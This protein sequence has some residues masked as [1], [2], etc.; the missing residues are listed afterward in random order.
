[1]YQFI[2]NGRVL[3]KHVAFFQHA[4]DA[5][6]G[7]NGLRKFF[8]GGGIRGGK[9][10][11]CLY[12]IIVACRSYQ[13]LRAH[14]IRDSLPSL[15]RTI[16]PSIKKLLIGVDHKFS[17]A[18]GNTFF[19]FPNGSE[20]HL[21]AESFDS[22]KDLNRFKG[23]ETNIIFLEQ[24]EELNSLTYDKCIERVGS[25]VRPN[26]ALGEP[27][28]LILATMNPTHVSW[29]RDLIYNPFVK[30]RV[31]EDTYISMITSE[32]NPF[33]TDDQKSNW[34]TMT[35]EMYRQYVLGDWDVMTN[36]TAFLYAFDRNKHVKE[37]PHDSIR[38]LAKVYLSAD[39]NVEPLCGILCY[40]NEA[41][42][43]L[44]V[45]K[46]YHE[47]NIDVH[48]WGQKI[49]KD[50]GNRHLLI[51]GDASGNNRSLHL[52]N[53]TLY[54]VLIGGLQS[55][56]AGVTS[57][58]VKVPAANIKHVLSRNI[59][60]MALANYNITIHP[61]C[62]HLIE[63]IMKVKATIEG[64]ID[65]KDKDLTHLLDCFRYIIH[66]LFHDKLKTYVN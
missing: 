5:L 49:A 65:K 12:T 18:A 60:N 42:N 27:K 40:Y 7:K 56:G 13:N 24:I 9:T 32:E 45:Y 15:N 44:H 11:L 30:N 16:L 51:T 23:L 28:P 31:P 34:K 17:A 1:M 50:V 41:T 14:I 36:T 25:W 64:T 37:E 38:D 8:F 55:G 62:K 3:N 26:A 19:R 54:Q 52:N 61:S 58:N 2:V 46:E 39:F 21:M 33:V 47:S 48:R 10:Y 43:A 6:A 20:I 63:D 53:R 29:V 35:P 59:V 4:I 66:R 57:M 22:D